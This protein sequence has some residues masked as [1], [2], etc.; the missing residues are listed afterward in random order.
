MNPNRKMNC[1][2][3]TLD[4]PFSTII[5]KLFFK[6]KYLYV[7]LLTAP[8]NI[9]TP[10]ILKRFGTELKPAPKLR[11][12][13]IYLTHQFYL[14]VFVLTASRLQ[15]SQSHFPRRT[16]SFIKRK[17]LCSQVY[18]KFLKKLNASIIA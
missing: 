16:T 15:R 6:I 3:V 17:L 1:L 12:P 9:F 8:K 5:Q 14:G 10:L 7:P 18:F 13:A 2:F 11:T 4:F